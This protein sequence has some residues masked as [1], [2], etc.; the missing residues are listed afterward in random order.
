MKMTDIELKTLDKRFVSTGEFASR[1][2]LEA[3]V[4]QCINQHRQGVDTVATQLKVSEATVRRILKANQQAREEADQDGG[5]PLMQQ[6]NR[7]WRIPELPAEDAVEPG[8][9]CH[10]AQRR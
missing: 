1:E 9:V 3:Y 7:L 6:L 4:L 2:E 8:D 10:Y 5:I